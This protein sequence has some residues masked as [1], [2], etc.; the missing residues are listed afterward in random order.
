MI[1]MKIRNMANVQPTL[2]ISE[3]L[4]L[5]QN[6]FHLSNAHLLILA[7]KFLQRRNLSREQAGA[8]LSCQT[9][10]LWP[11][12]SGRGRRQRTRPPHYVPALCPAHRA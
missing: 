10:S 5:I 3:D 6:K 2:S 9:D 8:T 12:T 11:A 7:Q 4:F 1:L